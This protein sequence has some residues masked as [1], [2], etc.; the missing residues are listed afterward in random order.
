[1]KIKVPEGFKSSCVFSP[2]LQYRYILKREFK[3]DAKR[4]LVFIMLNPSTAD[5][6]SN[7]PTVLRCQNHALN[8]D[9]DGFIVLNIFAFRSTDPKNMTKQKDPVGK[10]NDK[11]ILKV[12]KKHK[13]IICA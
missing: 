9:F 3:K 4:F 13:D 7:D 5:E 10:D 12:L 11:H 1:M 2:C 6:S 8:R